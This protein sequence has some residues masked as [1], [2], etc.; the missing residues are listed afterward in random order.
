MI[1]NGNFPYNLL[2]KRI[3]ASKRRSGFSKDVQGQKD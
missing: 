2:K 3:F 1:T